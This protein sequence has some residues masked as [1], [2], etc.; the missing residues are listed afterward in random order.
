MNVFMTSIC[1]SKL[2]LVIIS[3]VFGPTG[4]AVFGSIIAD[5]SIFTL[6][7]SRDDYDIGKQLPSC[8]F[9][10]YM[11]LI[12]VCSLLPIFIISTMRKTFIG[13]ARMDFV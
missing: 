1:F 8:F 7:F 10:F 6:K 5:Y 4:F 3:G 13:L 12:I 11:I 9:D 2:A